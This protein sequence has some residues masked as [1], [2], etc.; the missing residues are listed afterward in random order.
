MRACVFTE[1]ELAA[2][3]TG[4]EWNV[5][6]ACARV[7]A[8]ALFGFQPMR[9]PAFARP[10]QDQ[11][12]PQLGRGV[13][14]GPF[15]I[16]YAG[17][18]IGEDTQVCPN[19]HIREGTSIGRRCVIGAG[20]HLGYDVTIGDDVKIMDDAHLGGGTTVGDRTFISVQVL[21]VN[22][23][24]PGGYQWK[25][26]TPCR[27]GAGVMLGAGARLRPGVTIGD[28]AIVGMGA[29]V[30][31]DVAPYATVMGVPARLAAR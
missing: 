28:G 25:G 26:I 14:I 17:C 16:I 15:A 8:T 11:P 3:S 31:R 10:V 7:H 9:G 12:P 2:M 5:T 22:D 13:V 6:P 19:A 23:D 20:V 29:V 21:A 18:T 24:R 1:A 27:I 4:D 30:T